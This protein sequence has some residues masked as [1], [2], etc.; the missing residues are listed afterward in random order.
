MLNI[1]HIKEEGKELDEAIEK[2][3]AIIDL[4]PEI[5]PHLTG[6]GFKLK[7]YFAKGG[8]ILQNG[9]VITFSRYKSNGRLSKNATSYKKKGDFILHQIASDRSKKGNSKKV[10]DEFVKY[11]NDKSLLHAENLFLTV[12]AENQKAVSFYERYGFVKDSDIH[13]NSKKE[14]LIKG[15]VFRL[16]LIPEKNIESIQKRKYKSK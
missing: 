16:R 7:K 2:V 8:V 13:W 11:C 14:G 12:R 6:Q 10:L 9:V 15:I 1:L 4:Y 5:F 3:M